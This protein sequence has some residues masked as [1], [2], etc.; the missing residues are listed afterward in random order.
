MN[1]DAFR[2]ALQSHEETEDELRTLDDSEFV[3]ICDADDAL[4]RTFSGVIDAR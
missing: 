1:E 2:R 3:E 4:A